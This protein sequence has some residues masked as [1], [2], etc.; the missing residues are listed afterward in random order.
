M[1]NSIPKYNS[2]NL[3]GTLCKNFKYNL[4]IFSSVIIVGSHPDLLG[5]ILISLIHMRHTHQNI[6]EKKCYTLNH[7]HVSFIGKARQPSE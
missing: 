5:V 2:A 6:R 7:I 3:P 1:I 4:D